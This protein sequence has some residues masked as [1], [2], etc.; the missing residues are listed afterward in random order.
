MSLHKE[1]DAEQPLEIVSTFMGAHVVPTEYRGKARRTQEYL[2]LVEEQLIPEVA[3]NR[4][5]EFCD[6]FCERGAF[7]RSE[8]R[9]VLEAGKAPA[10]V[11]R[12][13]AEQLEYWC[14]AN[15]IEL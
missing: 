3:K 4:L 9:R 1:L 12:V 15:G 5:A 6:V 7:S 11:P 10:L 8:S 13:H 2:E 14:G